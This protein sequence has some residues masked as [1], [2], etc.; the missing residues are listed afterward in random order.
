[1]VGIEETGYI[2]VSS[3]ARKIEIKI[4]Q[5]CFNFK[6]LIRDAESS[7]HV[8]S[9]VD[10][11]SAWSNICTFLINIMIFS[12]NMFAKFVSVIL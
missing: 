7:M 1:M 12:Y 4:L 10:R 8:S 9:S 3:L 11:G 6:N 2:L 5:E